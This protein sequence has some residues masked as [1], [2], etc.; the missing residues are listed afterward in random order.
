MINEHSNYKVTQ[1]KFQGMT[2]QSLEDIK[3]DIKELKGEIKSLRSQM[4]NIKLVSSTLGIVGG[5][6]VSV[7]SL[8]IKK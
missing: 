2:L 1:A 5:I 6:I 7:L 3:E 8:F 4:S